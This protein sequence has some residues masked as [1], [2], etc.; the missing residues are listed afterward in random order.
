MADLLL[1]PVVTRVTGKATDELV[2]S[3]TRMWGIDT[4]RGKLERLLC[5][6]QCMLP[7]AEVKGDVS[8]SQELTRT[9]EHKVPARE[10]MNTSC[11]RRRT[12]RPTQ[13]PVSW[14]FLFLWT[15][16]L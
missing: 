10:T 7:D 16:Q 14:H 11:F 3:V 9:H 2:Q 4:D 6:V 12:P 5:A 8:Y 15:W 1:L 13:R